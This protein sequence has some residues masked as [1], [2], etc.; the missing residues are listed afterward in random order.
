MPLTK[1]DQPSTNSQLYPTPDYQPSTPFTSFRLGPFDIQPRISAGVTY[2]DNILISSQNPE[3]DLIWSLKPAFLAVAGDRLAI[4]DYQRTYHDVVSFSP[5]TFIIT[6]QET[7]PG[8]TLMVDYG[9]QFNWFTST[10][11]TIPLTNS[12]MPMR[13]GRWAR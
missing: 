2:D 8:K 11:R 9:P 3:S 6:D 1:E 7:W 10:R 4:E 5:D 12:S 13:S